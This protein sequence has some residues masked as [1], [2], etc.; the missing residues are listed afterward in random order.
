MLTID[1]LAQIVNMLRRDLPQ[2][3]VWKVND[4]N[5]QLEFGLLRN[6]LEPLSEFEDIHSGKQRPPEWQWYL[7]F[8]EMQVP[9]GAS[10]LF[11][12]NS[13]D[14]AIYHVDVESDDPIRPLNHTARQFVECFQVLESLFTSN[15][16]QAIDALKMLERID[17]QTFEQSNEWRQLLEYYMSDE[18]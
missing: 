1:A 12:I 17:S 7:P 5:L 4:L 14:G 15:K 8:G 2:A 11:C 9:G 3:A 6:S 16:S 10:P 13:C 18:A